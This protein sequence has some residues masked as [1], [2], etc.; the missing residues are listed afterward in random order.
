MCYLIHVGVPAAHAASI[1]TQRSPR[2]DRHSNPSV[3]EAFGSDFALYSITDGGCSCR[4]YA[5]PGAR[6]RRSRRSESLKKKYE[7]LGWSE[8]KIARALASSNDALEQNHHDDGPGL[9]ADVAGYV[10]SLAESFGEVQLIVHE[11]RGSFAEE[12]VVPVRTVAMSAHE[13]RAAGRFA[14]EVDTVH[15]IRL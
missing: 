12:V 5:S 9:G 15:N 4:L 2:V 10:A 13:L 14:I 8:E 11:Y 6:S 3:A 7:R 1:R